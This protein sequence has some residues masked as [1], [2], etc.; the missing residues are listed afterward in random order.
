MDA[1]ACWRPEDKMPETMIRVNIKLVGLFSTGRFKQKDCSFQDGARIKDVIDE[2]QIPLNLLGIIL[3]NGIH[4]HID[5]PLNDE[6]D[7]V[8]LPLLDGG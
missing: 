1:V 3:V 7:L 2:L 4:V 6:D 5:S 8:L